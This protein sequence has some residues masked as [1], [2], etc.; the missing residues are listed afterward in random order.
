MESFYSERAAERYAEIMRN[1]PAT[2]SFNSFE[3]GRNNNGSK[4]EYSVNTWYSWEG[5]GA[6]VVQQNSINIDLAANS[7]LIQIYFV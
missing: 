1:V 2:F 6:Y 4:M 3:V 5:F 7:I